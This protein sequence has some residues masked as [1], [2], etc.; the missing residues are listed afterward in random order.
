MPGRHRLYDAALHFG[1]KANLYDAE[2]SVVF[3]LL[4][5]CNLCDVQ[6][7]GGELYS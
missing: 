6:T 1:L 3:L 5:P 2:A 7:A 4:H